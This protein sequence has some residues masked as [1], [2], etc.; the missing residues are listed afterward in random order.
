[1]RAL[2]LTTLNYAGAST[3][4]MNTNKDKD[5]VQKQ[6][7]FNKDILERFTELRTYNYL[8]LFSLRLFSLRLFSAA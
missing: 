3:T 7:K 5:L 4:S 1:M 8:R 2:L 6:K